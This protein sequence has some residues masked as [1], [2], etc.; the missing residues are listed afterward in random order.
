MSASLCV[1]RPARPFLQR[2]P[3]PQ[4]RRHR[5]FSVTAYLTKHGEPQL[6]RSVEEFVAAVNKRDPDLLLEH[7]E[8]YRWLWMQPR[9]PA[10]LLVRRR[11]R[12]RLAPL[13]P[14]SACCH[15]MT[16]SVTQGGVE[17]PRVEQGR[18]G[19]PQEGGLPRRQRRP[20]EPAFPFFYEAVADQSACPSCRPVRR[21]ARCTQS[22]LQRCRTITCTPT[23]C[24][25]GPTPTRSPCTSPPQVGAERRGERR[26][27][28]FHSRMPEWIVIACFSLHTTRLVCRHQHG[29]VAGARAQRPPQHVFRCM[30]GPGWLL[31]HVSLLVLCLTLCRQTN[32][33]QE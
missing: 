25:R 33:V 12:C 5:A 31:A 6:Q 21:C 28:G 27:L 8:F 23:R 22:C 32:C 15:S 18:C 14:T 1:S 11:R 17:R 9:K 20:L 3:Q 7:R 29:R 4:T 26:R 10:T 2:L 16:C 24:W 13:C 30:A 19:R